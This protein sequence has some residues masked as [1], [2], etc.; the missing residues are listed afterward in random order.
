M[1]QKFRLSNEQVARINDAL[2]AL[3]DVLPIID[4]AERCGINCQEHRRDHREQ[5]ERFMKLLTEF[6]E[7]R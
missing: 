4:A 2:Q 1:A 5:Y 6:A 7:R 3:H